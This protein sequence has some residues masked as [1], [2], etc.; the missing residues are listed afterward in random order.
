MS[1]SLRL[2][3]TPGELA[4]LTRGCDVTVRL[5]FPDGGGWLVRLSSDGERLEAASTAAGA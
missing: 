1:D 4:D 3:I 2:R 5:T